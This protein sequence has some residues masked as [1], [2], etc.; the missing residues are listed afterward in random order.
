MLIPRKEDSAHWYL[1]DGTPFH[2]VLRADGK[3]LRSANV[4]DAFKVGAYRSVTNVLGV[5]GKPGLV[6][7]QIEQAILSALTLPRKADET[8]HQFAARALEDS[9]VQGRKAAEFGTQL[10]DSAANYLNYRSIPTD[11]RAVRLLPP[12]F[13][14]VETNVDRVIAAERVMVN[15]ECFY[16]GRLDA[17]LSMRD[18][19]KAII[20]LKT[21]DVKRGTKGIPKPA[22]Y[23][24]WA[25]QLSAYAHCEWPDEVIGPFGR[26]A[27]SWRL[28]SIVI[29]RTEPGIYLK[30]WPETTKHFQSFLA[31]GIC[32]GYAKGGVPGRD[33][34]AA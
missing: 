24:E 8:D 3:G 9:E 11:E 27:Q 12:F 5:L 15:R 6:K 33:L 1:P 19:S 16:A 31:A 10:H 17:A 30:E 34:E 13:R 7:W 32:W 25:M 2:D 23:D 22:F 26:A 18:G 4:T 28:I 14:W 29:D 20:D 21:Q